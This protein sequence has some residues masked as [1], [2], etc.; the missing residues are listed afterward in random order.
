MLGKH[1]TCTT[2]CLQEG[3]LRKNHETS[4][5]G[6]TMLQF[7]WKY[8]ET[9]VD[10]CRLAWSCIC[11]RPSCP[12]GWVLS[13]SDR[14]PSKQQSRRIC[15]QVQLNAPRI[16]T[17]E[18]MVGERDGLEVEGN[19]SSQIKSKKTSNVYTAQQSHAD[20]YARTIGVDTWSHWSTRF[21]QFK[22]L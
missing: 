17:V 21:V 4:W 12:Q 14:R 16:S 22:F 1:A 2:S 10:V 5:N 6:K 7:I 13:V 11:A 18:E 9:A 20:A 19:E 3:R 15:Q 8:F